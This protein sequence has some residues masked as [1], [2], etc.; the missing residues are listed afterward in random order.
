[1]MLTPR[2]TASSIGAL[3]RASIIAGSR[4]GQDLAA[5]LWSDVMSTV[6]GSITVPE[7]PADHYR[8]LLAA[9][10]GA[11]DRA[12]E[13]FRTALAAEMTLGAPLHTAET[14]RELAAS[15]ARC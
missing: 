9:A 11:H 2:L 3:T 1:M 12:V 13:L 14:E 8:A 4:R 10:S 6:H 5:R 15:L 7:F